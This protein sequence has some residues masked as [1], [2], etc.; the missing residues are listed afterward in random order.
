GFNLFVLL[1]LAG[2][3]GVFHRHAHEVSM[4]EAAGWG[5][6]WVTLTLLFNYGVYHFMGGQAGS[7]RPRFLCEAETVASSLTR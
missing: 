5:V 6:V 2:D 4:K 1:M 3:L 7:C